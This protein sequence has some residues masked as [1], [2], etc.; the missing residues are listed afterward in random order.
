MQGDG[1]V[2][3]GFYYI[4]RFNPYSNFYLS[5]GINYPNALDK[6]NAINSNP[7]GDIF[8]H[9]NCVTIG[10]IPIT[11]DNIKELYLLAIE[12]KEHGQSKIPVHI[13]PAKFSETNWKNLQNKNKQKSFLISFWTDMKPAY[14]Y[15]E[16][17]KKVPSVKISSSGKYLIN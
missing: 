9:G 6:K 3:E 8:I 11:D 15:F 7:G 5:L 14:D 12:A 4:D 16:T 2:P 17:H 1:Q 13:F 10:C